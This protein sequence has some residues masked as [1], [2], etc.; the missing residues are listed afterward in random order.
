MDLCLAALPWSFIPSL[1][2]KM[3]EKFGMG[4]AMSMGAL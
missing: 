2:M 1:Q 3:R 4:L